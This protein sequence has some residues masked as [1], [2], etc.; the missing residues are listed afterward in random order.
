MHFVSLWPGYPLRLPVKQPGSL[1]TVSTSPPSASP[2][3]LATQ[4]AARKVVEKMST[5]SARVLRRL[6]PLDPMPYQLESWI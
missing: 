6:L 3:A 2:P 5:V 1:L 4:V